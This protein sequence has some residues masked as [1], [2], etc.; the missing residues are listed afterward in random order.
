MRQSE[1]F[2]EENHPFADRFCFNR[3][4]NIAVIRIARFQSLYHRLLIR[5]QNNGQTGLTEL[6]KQEFIYI[7]VRFCSA[8]CVIR[9]KMAIG[10]NVLILVYFIEIK[11]PESIKKRRKI[12]V[13]I[14]VYLIAYSD[15]F[16]KASFCFIKQQMEGFL[17][18]DKAQPLCKQFACRRFSDPVH[19]FD[20]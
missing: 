17:Y 1:F 10:D 7:F 12:S 8:P 6:F 18:K 5:S 15:I 16:F 9:S 14:P 20:R 13:R 2:A 3:F 4:L 19:S 11:T